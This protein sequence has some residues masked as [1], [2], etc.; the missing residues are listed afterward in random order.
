MA[1]GTGALDRL[2]LVLEQARAM[3][4]LGPGRVEAHI[5][6]AQAYG[7]AIARL[8]AGLGAPGDDPQTAFDA[9]DLG[10]GAGVPGLALALLWPRS[11][12][13]LLDAGRRRCDFVRQAVTTLD[14]DERVE[15]IEGR[16]EEVG[17]D[18]QHRGRYQVVTARG[19]G[20]PGVTAECAAP[21]L[22][23]AGWL[24]VSEPPEPDVQRWPVSALEELG[25]ESVGLER[26]DQD[27]GATAR[28][29]AAHQAR[30]CPDR[31][32]RR[33]GVPMKRPLF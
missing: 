19:F 7:E 6:H 23:T 33:T 22:A 24:L 18:P 17:R 26:N 13:H 9:L 27:G 25:L 28:I 4:L 1:S 3:G 29:F 30:A 5:H 12:W 32:P 2:V 21:L 31:Y 20:P 11:R 10:S 16:A 8:V 14:L 15:V